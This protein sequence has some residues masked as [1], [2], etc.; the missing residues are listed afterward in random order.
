MDPKQL[1]L[2]SADEGELHLSMSL[3]MQF[4]FWG[5][6]AGFKSLFG[7]GLLSSLSSIMRNT[8]CNKNKIITIVIS[9]LFWDK[10]LDDKKVLASDSCRR[11]TLGGWRVLM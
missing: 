2:R 6:S 5:C 8:V 9:Y 4:R 10:E 3:R 7:S 11:E 1:R